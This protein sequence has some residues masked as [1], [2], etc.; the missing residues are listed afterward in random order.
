VTCGMP[1]ELATGVL[2]GRDQ[3]LASRSEPASTSLTV[4]DCGGLPDER[5][6]P[7]LHSNEHVTRQCRLVC[8]AQA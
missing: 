2:V 6:T 8:S 5:G 1:C 4:I 3:T 7:Q